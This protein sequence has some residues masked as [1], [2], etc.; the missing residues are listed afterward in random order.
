MIAVTAPCRSAQIR[1]NAC[2]SEC[3]VGVIDRYINIVFDNNLGRYRF[4][5]AVFR[6]DPAVLPVCE[7]GRHRYHRRRR[8]FAATRRRAP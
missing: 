2:G 3:I 4:C 1:F 8:L 5:P 7:S 6:A